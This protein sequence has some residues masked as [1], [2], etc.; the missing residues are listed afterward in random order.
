MALS[1]MVLSSV[2][3]VEAQRHFAKKIVNFYNLYQYV[4]C[5]V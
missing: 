5:T 2:Y 4:T 1:Y 3:F